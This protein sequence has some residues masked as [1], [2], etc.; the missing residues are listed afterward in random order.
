MVPSGR[1]KVPLA[2]DGTVC[3]LLVKVRGAPR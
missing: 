2:S 1:L 3:A